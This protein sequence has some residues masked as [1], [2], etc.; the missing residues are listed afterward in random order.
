[1]T[2]DVYELLTRELGRERVLR[3]P[4]ALEDYGRDES[5]PGR[6]PARRGGAVR[7]AR[8]D[9][10][11][12]AAGGRAQRPGHAAR[13]RQ[14]HDRRRAAGARRH[15]A[16][17]RAHAPHHRDRRPTIAS[18]SSSRASSTPTCR[19]RSRRRGC[20]T[21]PTRPASAFCSIGGNVAE[22]AGGP[23]A[24]KYGVTRDY[25]RPEVDA[26]GRR[27]AAP[28]PA[29]PQGRHRLRPDRAVRRQRGHVRRDHR[30]H[31]CSWSAAPRASGRS[32]RCCPTR[33]R[34]GARSA[35]SS[36]RGTGRARSSC[37]TARRS[38]TCARRRRTRSRPTRARSCWSSSTASPT[39]IEAAVLAL[40][41]RV[42]G[43][44]RAR[45]DR[46]ARRRRPRAAVEDAAACARRRCAR[47]TSSSCPRT[48]VVPPSSIP[49]M[50]RRVDAIGARHDLQTATF[51]HAGDGNLH[52][53]LLSHE[54]TRDAA[55]AARVDAA[56]ADAV[57]GDA[58]SRRHAVGRARHRHREGA[59]HGVG[60][61]ARGAS[62]G[63]SG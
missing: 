42:R 18:P 34:R 2:D 57:Q 14:R 40:R 4:E 9:R 48:S 21:R 22:N 52:V 19:P 50:L 16:V 38:I 10:A 43:R 41:R 28:R 44:G 33:C 1:M 12:A 31:A 7:V 36:A 32:S 37:S 56:L 17:D 23:R 63:R 60:A 54:T 26:D 20:S 59:L 5:R 39:G 27:D 58:G 11:R 53:N 35:R 51:G 55:F 25:A 6:L 47:R 61:V 46:R 15:R 45:R 62:S 24:F 29:H 3:A 13:R 8:G 49:E 30:D